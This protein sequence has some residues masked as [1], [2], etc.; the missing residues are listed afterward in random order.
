MPDDPRASINS[1]INDAVAKL[2]K[3]REAINGAKFSEALAMLR[4]ARHDAQDAELMLWTLKHNQDREAVQKAAER[5]FH[6]ES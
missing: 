1:K 3:A 4:D 2:D 6:G 5:G